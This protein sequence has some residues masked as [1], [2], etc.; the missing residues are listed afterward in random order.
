MAHF[1]RRVTAH[2]PGVVD[3]LASIQQPTLILVGEK[4]KAFLRAGEVM[5]AR[6]PDARH[7]VI[8]DAG[9]VVNI[10][11]A[12]RFQREVAAFL[13]ALPSP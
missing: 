12:E 3:D 11:Q 8:P 1:G 4:D 10:E 7:V 6:M 9:H 13:E 2:A 5:A